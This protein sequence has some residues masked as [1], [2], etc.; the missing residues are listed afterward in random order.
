MKYCLVVRKKLVRYKC[1]LGTVLMVSVSRQCGD[2]VLQIGSGQWGMLA[3][4]DSDNGRL[5][6]YQCKGI[7]GPTTTPTP[8]NN[9]NITYQ[10]KNTILLGLGQWGECFG[11]S[12]AN[13]TGDASDA[14]L[15]S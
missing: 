10:L 7:C 12:K 4:W 14:A 2:A 11:S 8:T 15:Q 13:A 9:S 1:D 3:Y 5:R 6:L